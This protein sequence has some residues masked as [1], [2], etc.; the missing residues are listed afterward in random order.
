MSLGHTELIKDDYL[1]I[2]FIQSQLTNYNICQVVGWHRRWNTNVIWLHM[3]T[4]IWAE[5]S[6]AAFGRYFQTHRLKNI[7]VVF[8]LPLNILIITLTP[9][10]VLPLF[11]TRFADYAGGIRVSFI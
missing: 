3:I 2:Y 6:M 8:L 4:D 1:D 7:S 10:M 5:M 11:A 9:Y